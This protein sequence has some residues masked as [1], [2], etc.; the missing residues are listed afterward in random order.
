VLSVAGGKHLVLLQSGIHSPLCLKGRA[1]KMKVLV[2]NHSA[3]RFGKTVAAGIQANPS[4]ADTLF[5][6]QSELKMGAFKNFADIY[7][8]SVA[9]GKPL[10]LP[11]SGIHSPSR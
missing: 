6:D 7:V 5:R 2:I 8:L 4:Q 11:Q 1:D 3:K 10:F 9:G